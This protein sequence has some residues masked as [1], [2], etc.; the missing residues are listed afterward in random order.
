MIKIGTSGYSFK[1]WVGN[2]YPQNIKPGK[3]LDYYQEHFNTVEINSTY[4]RLPHPKIFENI[5]KKVPHDFE[6]I[7]KV[8]NS[9]THGAKKNLDS[10]K[11]LFIGID[12]IIRAGK[13][14][15]FLA[16]FPYA[17]KY[18]DK[19]LE[20][21]AKVR[22]ECRGFPLF[23]EFRHISWLRD[24]V[25]QFLQQNNTGYVNV[26]EPPL[27]GLIPPQILVTN[28]I[29]Y[30]RFHGRNRRTWWDADVGDRYDYDYSREELAEWLPLIQ[31]IS[32][33]SSETFIFFNNCH[34]GQAV[35]NAKMMRDMIK[36]QLRLEVI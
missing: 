28:N 35:K 22:K 29:G 36:D 1:E 23:I 3:M 10:I 32:A 26:D 16:Q 13:F 21:L 27:H 19:N 9:I 5:V 17:F 11:E 7:V 30:I 31:N 25:Y 15:G 12:P 2:F 6:F 4:Y 8:H 33:E 24:E 18:S 14:K 34:M 20:H